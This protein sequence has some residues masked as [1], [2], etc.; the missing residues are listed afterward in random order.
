MAD[1]NENVPKVSGSGAGAV[2][3]VSPI[4]IAAAATTAAVN[5]PLESRSSVHI[6]DLIGEGPNVGIVDAAT[7]NVGTLQKGVFYDDTLA[8]DNAG[9]ANVRVQ[10]SER[11][12]N[13]NQTFMHGHGSVSTANGGSFPAAVVAATP[14]IRRVTSSN[15][16]QVRIG[17]ALPA[18]LNITEDDDGQTHGHK[19]SVKIEIKADADNVGSVYV[20]RV[21]DVIMGKTFDPYERAYLIALDGVAPWDIRVTRVSPD[22]VNGPGLS[23]KQSPTYW[24]Y[25]TEVVDAK[26]S[27][28]DRHVVGHIIDGKQFAGNVPNRNFLVKGRIIKVPSN[29]NPT[30]RTYTGEWNGLFTDAWSN[31]PVW[32]LYD[33]LTHTRYGLGDYIAE[34]D[35][36]K[37]D[38]YQIAQYCDAWQ[39]RGVVG[40]AGK[41]NDYHV[42]TGAHGVPDGKGGF[43]PRFTFNAAISTQQEAIAL[44]QTIAGMFRSSLIWGGEKFSLMTNRQKTVTKVYNRAN[45][46]D[47]K[48]EYQGTSKE[49]RHSVAMVSWTN[50]E[51]NAFD[52]D[53]MAVDLPEAIERYGYNEL[54]VAAVGCTSPGQ[55]YRQGLAA[56][57]S[58]WLETDAVTFEVGITDAG[59]TLGSVIGISDPIFTTERRGG[60]LAAV[61]ST[62]NITLDAPY[63]FSGARTYKILIMQP[64]GTVG[65]FNV[66]NPN[67]TTATITLSTALSGA[68]LPAKGAVWVLHDDLVVTRK[69]YVMGLSESEDEWIK[70][71]ALQYEE[72]KFAL[73]DGTSTRTLPDPGTSYSNIDPK[74]VAAPTDL[75]LAY[76]TKT[77]GNQLYGQVEASWPASTTPTIRGYVVA[78]QFGNGNIITMPEQRATS[79]TFTELERSRLTVWVYSV[80]LFGVRSTPIFRTMDLDTSSATGK[81]L[82]TNLQVQGGGTVW[83]GRDINVEWNAKP[84]TNIDTLIT[85]GMDEEFYRFRVRLYT[86]SGGV[87]LGTLNTTVTKITIPY[88]SIAAWS[89]T[90]GQAL[91]RSYYV[92]VELE[93]R[94]GT[95][96]SVAGATFTNPAPTLPTI[97][98]VQSPG[99]VTLQFSDPTDA[100]YVGIRVWASLTNGF[101]P[102]AGNLV[103]EGAGN[104]TLAALSG[105]TI[106]YVYE[107]FDAFGSTSLNRSAQQTTAVG[108]VSL[109]GQGD[110]AT[111]N[112]AVLPFGGNS[113]ANSEFISG[114]SY[115]PVGWSGGVGNI[116][117]TTFTGSVI[118]GGAR[119]AIKAVL[120]GTTSGGT[121]YNA[122][123]ATPTTTLGNF[124]R[125][126]LPVV[127][128]DIVGASA[129]LAKNAAVSSTRVDIIWY[130]AAAAYISEVAG[131]SIATSANGDTG[132]PADYTLSSVV[133]TAPANARF[134]VFFVRSLASSGAVNPTTWLMS[135]LLCRLQ[136][137]QTVVPAYQPGAVDRSADV[138]LTNIASSVTGQGDLATQTRASLA[139][140]QNAVI[141]SGMHRGTAALET[142]YSSFG[143]VAITRLVSSGQI[144]Y[145]HAY[146]TTPGTLSAG[147]VFDIYRSPISSLALLQRYGLPIV[148]GDRIFASCLGSY[149]GGA[150]NM[151]VIVVFFDG[152]GVYITENGT[153]GGATGYPTTGDPAAFARIGHL[154]TAP[155]NAR[156]A[157]I[158]VRVNVPV[159]N[160]SDGHSYYAQPML[161]RVPAGQ[162]AWPDYNPGPPDRLSDQT[163][164][165]TA[166]SVVGQTAIATLPVITGQYLGAG[167]GKNGLYDT[168][169]RY[170]TGN[171]RS[172][173]A[174]GSVATV[175]NTSTAGVRRATLTGTGVG[176][177]SYIQLDTNDQKFAFPVTPGEYVEGSAYVGGS[178]LT[179][180]SLFIDFRNAAGANVG[181]SAFPSDATPSAGNGELST[182]ELLATV[183]Q[184]VP[185]GAVCAYLNIRGTASTSAPVLNVTKPLLAKSTQG[186]TQATPWHLGFDGEAGANITES[187]QAA[188]ILNQGTLATV[189][190]AN[191]VALAGTEAINNA[192]VP[193]GVNAAPNSEFSLTT[194]Y[195][196]A[197]YTSGGTG[198]LA[199][200]T[201]TASIVTAGP[202][203]AI[204]SIMTGTVSSGSYFDLFYGHYNDVANARRYQLPV[205]AGDLVGASALVA[206][207]SAVSG[208]YVNIQWLN[209]TGIYVGEVAGNQITANANGDTGNPADYA[210]STVIAA[211]PAGTR[212]ANIYVRCL[213]VASA[214]N[215]TGW[216]MSPLICRLAPGQTAVPAYSPG[217]VDRNADN[218]LTNTAAAI[219]NQGTGALA[220]NLAG[221]NA[222]D[223]SNLNSALAGIRRIGDVS[224]FTADGLH[225]TGA[226]GGTPE[227][228]ADPT[229][230]GYFDVPSIGRVIR[231]SP[232]AYL[233]K[234][235]VFKPVQGRRYLLVVRLRAQTNPS[236]GA[237]T[238][239]LGNVNGLSTAYAHGGGTATV[240][241]PPNAIQSKANFVT[242]D[243]WITLAALFTAGAPSTF[244]AYWRLRLDV[245]QSGAG[246]KVEVASF[247]DFDVTDIP[248][249]RNLADLFRA[250]GSTPLSDS[251]VITSLGQALSILNQ[252]WGATASEA[253]A[254]ASFHGLTKNP[255]F[256]QPFTGPAIPPLWSEWENGT[257]NT[258]FIAKPIGYGYCAQINGVATIHTGV[259]QNVPVA[260]SQDYI[261]VGEI[262]RQSG[263]LAGAGIHVNFYNSA[264]VAIGPY[265]ISFA[266]EPTTAGVTTSTPDG[267]QRWEKVI[268]APAGATYCL[269]YAMSHW[270]GFGG[271]IA[272]ANSIAW[273]ECSITPMSLVRQVRADVTLSNQAASFT[274]QGWGATASEA[275]AGNS[276]VAFGENLLV[277]TDWMESTDGWYNGWDGNHGLSVTRGMDLGGWSGNPVRTAFVKVDG[278]PG[279]GTVADGLITKTYD[280]LADLKRWAP[281][282]TPGERIYAS[283]YVGCHRCTAKLIVAFF[284][285]NGI[286]IGASE[287]NTVAASNFA[288]GNPANAERLGGFCTVPASACYVVLI[289][290]L[291]SV[292]GQA[293]PYLFHGWPMISK[294]SATQTVAPAYRTG[295]VDRYVDYTPENTAG[296]IAGQGALATKH[297]ALNTD[298]SVANLAAINANLGVVTTGT[299]EVGSGGITIQSAASGTRIVITDSKLEVYSGSTLRVRLGIW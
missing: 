25:L 83:S 130:D 66:T 26:V 114:A 111:T 128:G 56:L 187:R 97:T 67:T 277:N 222:T 228:V 160:V 179:S 206:K 220:N 89:T 209:D 186:Q 208:I 103:W 3:G 259:V 203:R 239:S 211:A 291:I 98:H 15:A 258:T 92:T 216:A 93:T 9:A 190:R 62:T 23:N 204:K 82:I 147:G 224:D 299:L 68:N 232:T 234:K 106:Y 61:A 184:L 165:N 102:G 272:V 134:A 244:D 152:A 257:A 162:T 213:P 227:T 124:Q 159:S 200:V 182:F 85:T 170:L 2:V 191:V 16:T 177:A 43:E 86:Q 265:N 247:E 283:Y 289:P 42:T 293:D 279:V 158:V 127:A 269:I 241:T 195:P 157:G 59:L 167:V 125:W 280:N 263:T 105:S 237:M 238:V 32:V 297:V 154:A 71:L 107:A 278:T 40:V 155:A 196:P 64:D 38:F 212:F 242:T 231:L 34:A 28:A 197:G 1:G 136:A 135:P 218:T 63:T 151:A 145:A 153:N 119:R 214:V 246:G 54:A 295:K 178:N 249:G 44:I 207:N 55:A 243:G 229:T 248:V 126:S 129:L 76:V 198:N 88:D 47:G 58:E 254:R 79:Y 226:F 101:T 193:H 12:G 275:N 10:L 217:G 164:T 121:Y 48:F 282:V 240:T 285:S 118:T 161:C 5:T 288:D 251:I 50:P 260:A 143:A 173:A 281:R 138:T 7:Y 115:P 205:V 192:V 256:D 87:L 60:R 95:F 17:I 194:T 70:V 137:G 100:D 255:R 77:A 75:G 233:T 166:A 202:R 199:G 21:L 37:F 223:N 94:S 81:A 45:V 24:Q 117:G 215:A 104:P 6:V 171:W 294:A 22:D 113:V 80:N 35:I 142:G 72:A 11:V 13:P 225:W 253:A 78:F 150:T 176:V 181:F 298:I 65:E 235:S 131:N 273:Y 148:A 53:I 267:V 140:G 57:Y 69:F 264:G 172:V 91:R 271:S 133:A 8:M 270:S 266:T 109:V 236:S 30:L 99:Q 96:S 268:S 201:Q 149:A 262:R 51:G 296:A 274:G 175:I 141:D 230:D 139:F 284:G 276:Q 286:Y 245:T 144:N 116:T 19:V 112:R 27:Y 120:T 41:T 250:D 39:A 31:N 18:G 185:A 132:N 14:V 169:F 33:A 20:E 52:E 180:I 29:Y 174:T 183:G 188:S 73:I 210:L 219:V 110:L 108:T 84:S 123:Y 90:A 156:Y 287:F 168:E 46:K 189:S 4:S 49:A 74:T 292:G 163:L 36:E 290:R 122:M 252:G 221:L 261:L 146:A